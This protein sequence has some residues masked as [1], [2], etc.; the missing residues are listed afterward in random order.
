MGITRVA[1]I[2]GLDQVGIPV[3]AAV[4]PQSRSLAVAQ[5]KGLTLDEAKVSAIMEAAETFHAERISQPVL[6]G[7]AAT[8]A[9]KHP[10]V[11]DVG[12]L[13]W[14]TLGG[15]RPERAM[16]WL[17]GADLASGEPIWLPLQSVH[18]A[19]TPAAASPSGLYA[20][21]S[22]LAAGASYGQAIGHGIFE[23]V[24][25]DAAVLHKLL[26][27]EA[28]DARRIDVASVDDAVPCDLIGRLRLAGL[29]IA[30]W[31]IT[32]EIG[33][34]VFACVIGETAPQVAAAPQL[35]GGFGCHFHRSVALAKALTEAAQSRLT[36]IAGAREDL[37][38]E[39]YA[40]QPDAARM[41]ECAGGCGRDYRA[42]PHHP[43]AEARAI[44]ELQHDHLSRAGFAQV[45]VVDL[46]KPEI[47]IPVV[48]VVVPGLEIALEPDEAVPGPRMERRLRPT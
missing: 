43:V 12:R 2:T 20:C 33:I 11:V 16:L 18:T 9:Q 47:G 35:A 22:G 31:D 13:P 37:S 38:A 40:P 42:A 19:Y 46:A 28:Q 17:E 6:H 27:E 3:A 10:R 24:E 8:I 34:A 44:V 30:I 4:R 36:A 45:L 15:Y 1:N 48:R 5:G 32:T 29:S 14:S 23:V 21:T 25:R 41:F 7:D 39:G 26:A